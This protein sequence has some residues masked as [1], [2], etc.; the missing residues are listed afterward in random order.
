MLR[1]KH[2][3]AVGCLLAVNT[4]TETLRSTDTNGLATTKSQSMFRLLLSVM[5][6][7]QKNESLCVKGNARE[8]IYNLLVNLNVYYI[9]TF[10]LYIILG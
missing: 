7:V 3:Q 10:T 1:E 5:G 4:V 6:Y 9:P 8:L 2:H